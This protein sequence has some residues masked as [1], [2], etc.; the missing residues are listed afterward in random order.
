MW[1][2]LLK[3][4]PVPDLHWS[5]VATDIFEWNNHHHLV[6]MDSYSG[7]F[8]VVWGQ[9]A[10]TLFDRGHTKALLKQWHS[11]HVSNLPK[12]YRVMG[13]PSHDN[14]YALK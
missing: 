2:E 1:K 3:Q 12:L 4:H 9:Q 6:L 10:Q 8:G 11:V 7:W 13:L 14:H 5:V